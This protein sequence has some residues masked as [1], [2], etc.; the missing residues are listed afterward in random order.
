MK[1]SLRYRAFILLVLAP[2]L[3]L[4]PLVAGFPRGSHASTTPEPGETVQAPS[5]DD[6]AWEISPSSSPEPLDGDCC[7]N[8]CDG[9]FL[10]CCEGLLSLEGPAQAGPG[11]SGTC[12]AILSPDRREL[13][14]VDPDLVSPPPRS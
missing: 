13:T 14:S 3:L 2:A 5:L 6:P 7:S 8:D 12:I 10:S 4:G 11:P 9:C 1:P